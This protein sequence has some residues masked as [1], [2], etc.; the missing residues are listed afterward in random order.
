MEVSRKKVL[1][2]DSDERLLI[3]L[4]RLLEDES[5]ETTT[6]WSAADGLGLLG[7]DEFDVLLMGD[8]LPDLSCEQLLR[9]VQRNG[10]RSTVLVMETAVPR[11]SSLASYFISLG[12]TGTV[13][14][15]NLG[16]TLDRVKTVPIL[17]G[18]RAA[19]AA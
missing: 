16:E 19:S 1:I 5:M 6:T 2:I 8:N 14:K 18:R 3:A 7:P 4:E 15:W 13:R 10:I 9:E 17:S 12:A 11:T